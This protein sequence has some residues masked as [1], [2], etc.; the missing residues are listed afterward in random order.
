MKEQTGY[1]EGAKRSQLF[2]EVWLPDAPPR[3]ALVIVHGG[4]EHINR[5]K[6]LVD[7]LVPAGFIL[8]GYDQRGHGRSEGQRGHIDS[9]S[10][11]REDIRIFL[12]LAGELARGLPMFLF[13][14][15]QG[16]LEVL[17]Y[18]L[19]YADGLA[20]AI[21]S[22]T[23]LYPE[24]VAPPH[25][26]L[27]ARVLSG[28]VPRFPLR[29]SVEGTSLSR[30]PQVAKAYMEDPLVHWSHSVRWGTEGLRIIERIKGRGGEINMPVLFLHGECDP[31]VSAA[32]ARRFFE[33]IRYPDKTFH[34]Y[35]EGLHEPHNDL[36][37]EQA[38]SDIRSWM[39]RHIVA[40]RGSVPIQRSA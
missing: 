18:I 14:H 23:A 8:T 6:N 34:I 37:Y 31:L 7:G 9:W 39:D 2:Y 22:A 30:D 33:E 10:E 17:D 16:S 40:S 38:I 13:G 21:I 32:G 12:D 26:V 11:Y 1:F 20:G 36:C 15:S 5:Y 25:L 19:H 3:A 28:I 29:L 4:G 35:P 27:L 24:G